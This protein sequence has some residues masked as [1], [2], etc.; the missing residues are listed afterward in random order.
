M[1]NLCVIFCWIWAGVAQ[2]LVGWVGWMI[3]KLDPNSVQWQ[4]FCCHS[5]ICTGCG[6]HSASSPVCDGALC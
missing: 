4:Q 5:C 3:G 1:V 2:S 6:T